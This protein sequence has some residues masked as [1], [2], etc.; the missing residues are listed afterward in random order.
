MRV[1]ELRRGVFSLSDLPRGFREVAWLRRGDCFL[2]D[3]DFLEADLLEVDLLDVDLLG[4][5]FDVLGMIFVSVYGPR[6]PAKNPYFR[7]L[8]G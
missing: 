8:D 2:L 5:D 4:V 7:L 3:V 6:I 1:P